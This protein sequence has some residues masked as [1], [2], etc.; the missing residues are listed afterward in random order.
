[1]AGAGSI[2]LLCMTRSVWLGLLISL[3]LAAHL[4]RRLRGMILALLLGAMLAVGAT[5]LFLGEEAEN[6]PRWSGNR[7]VQV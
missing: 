2:V 6:Q 5:Y 1:M 7:L 3:L 4:E